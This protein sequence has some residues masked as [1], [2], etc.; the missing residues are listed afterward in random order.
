MTWV[1][2]AFVPQI[3]TQS[4]FAPLS[5]MLF[6]VPWE[7]LAPGP[8]G[9]YLEVV[10]V[11]PASGCFYEPVNLDDPKI[12]TKG[13]IGFQVHSGGPMEVRFKDVKLEVL[14]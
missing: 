8:I 3:T 12:S 1:C 5:E 13:L 11:D 14:K 7:E 6:K 9:E 4:D 10:D 2:T